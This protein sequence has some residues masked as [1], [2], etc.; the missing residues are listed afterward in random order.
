MQ[1][2]SS[3]CR[4]NLGHV[5]LRAPCSDFQVK[6]MAKKLHHTTLAKP[7]ETPQEIP[8]DTS[9]LIGLYMYLG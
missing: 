9:Q 8:Q 3:H 6:K 5:Q 2:N 4:W 1:L 7:L